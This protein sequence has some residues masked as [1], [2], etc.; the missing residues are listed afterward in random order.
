MIMR[1]Q[2]ESKILI[3]SM[4]FQLIGIKTQQ[5]CDFY[6]NLR[7]LRGYGNYDWIKFAVDCVK[8]NVNKKGRS[9]FW[10]FI[11]IITTQ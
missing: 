5:D 9:L 10:F 4:S 1:K 3:D 11:V 8:L 7:A 6:D 2:I